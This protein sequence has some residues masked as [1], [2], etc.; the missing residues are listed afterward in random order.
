M[1][2]KGLKTML[3]CIVLLIGLVTLF[4][5]NKSDVADKDGQTKVIVKI[6]DEDGSIYKENVVFSDLFT[7]SLHGLIF[8]LVKRFINFTNKIPPEIDKANAKKPPITIP[9]VVQFK[10]ASVVIV[11]PTDNPKKIVAA[12]MILFEAASNKR[13]VSLPISLIKLPNINIPIKGT[14][15]GTNKATTVVT[16]IGKRIFSTRRFLI[17]VFEGYF[18]SCSFILILNSFLVHH[19]LTTKGMITG[20][21][22]I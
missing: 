12:F 15:L 1:S 11:A 17:S 13:E 22:A 7:L 10:N 9:I 16:T 2:K 18:F 5:C 20:T 21:K 14:A 4:A 6:Q 8:F 3:V 19:S